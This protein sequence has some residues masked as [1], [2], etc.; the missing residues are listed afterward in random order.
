MYNYEKGITDFHGPFAEILPQYIEYKRALGFKYSRTTVYRLREMDGFFRNHGITEPVISREMYE[1]F[2]ALRPN[3]KNG[4]VASRRNAIREFARYLV[5]MGYHG[6]YTG[7][8][9]TRIFKR[10]FIPYILSKDEI[11]RIFHTLSDMC[12]TEPSYANDALRL[13]MSLYYCCGLRK[14]EAQD[15]RNGDIDLKTGKVVIREGKNNVSR[16]VVVSS[17][18]L[19]ELRSYLKKY[20]DRFTCGGY[21]FQ[22]QHGGRYSNHSLYQKYRRVLEDSKI[23]LRA[24]GRR[25]RLHDLRHTFC[26]RVLETMQK[27][28]TL[29]TDLPLLSVYLGHRSI[30]ETEYYLRLA[31]GNFENVLEQ[32]QTYQSGI[33]PGI[34]RGD[35]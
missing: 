23:P 7:Y 32:V 1:A 29:Y 5:L 22:N 35:E 33:F 15:L 16:I 17:S 20:P 14:S 30:L 4:G 10:D 34:W 31:Q 28:G 19:E 25:Q 8:D 9:D 18:L 13:L 12:G 3:K 2:T 21:L 24:D 11:K 26:I 27:K 6:I